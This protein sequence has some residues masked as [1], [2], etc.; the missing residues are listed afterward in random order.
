DIVEAPTTAGYS[1]SRSLR[2]ASRE[3]QAE[4]VE[5]T[6]GGIHSKVQRE[7]FPTPH[8][9]SSCQTESASCGPKNPYRHDAL[10]AHPLQLRSTRQRP[11]IV[12]SQVLFS[13]YGNFGIC[14]NYG[15][16]MILKLPIYQITQVGYTV[17]CNE[18][19]SQR[20]TH[21]RPV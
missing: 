4:G 18:K 13:N 19:T 20:P 15:N 1:P 11:E 14:G 21:I 16:L 17:R 3:V 12:G 5:Y 10:S 2:K 7:N 6:V 8:T 9:Y